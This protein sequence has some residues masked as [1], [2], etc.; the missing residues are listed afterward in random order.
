MWGG[1]CYFCIMIGSMRYFV[2]IF[3]AMLCGLVSSSAHAQSHI[4]SSSEIPT[5]ALTEFRL[6][7]L[8]RTYIYFRHDYGQIDSNYRDNRAA[9]AAI[10]KALSEIESDSLSS[11]SSIVVEGTASVLGHPDYN[12]R[13]SYQRAANVEKFL[14]TL[15]GLKDFDIRLVAKGED[16][17]T[18]TSDIRNNYHRRNKTSLLEILESENLTQLQKKD[19]I[20][21]MEPDSLTWRILIRDNM[22]TSRHAVTVVVVRKERILQPLPL[23]EPFSVKADVSEKPLPVRYETALSSQA[24]DS[25]SEPV[26]EQ[27]GVPLLSLR[28]NLLVP[29]LNVGA[30]LPLGNRW[31]VAADYYFPWIWTSQKNRNCFELLGWSVEGRYWFGKGRQASDRLK[32]H[33]VGVYMAAGYYD[34]ERNFRGMQGEF[35]SPGVDYT[36][37]MAVGKAKRVHLQFTLALGYIHSWGRTYDV[38]GEYGELYPDEGTLMWDYFGPTKAA[39]SIVVPFYRKEG[40]R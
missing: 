22:N 4:D 18:F 19:R 9:L 33:S 26:P 5:A 20:R 12:F 21:S 15:P 2:L 10:R 24:K 35:V 3:F 6:D 14:R 27:S 1:I 39:V 30:E 23:L 11:I 40:R 25:V 13:L 16:W 34:F 8:A 7:T 17:G 38:Y 36:Y 31:S 28:S 32:G 29:I 37:S